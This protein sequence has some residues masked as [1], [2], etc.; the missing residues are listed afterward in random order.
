M[1]ARCDVS[2]VLHQTVIQLVLVQ[3]CKLLHIREGSEQQP[4]LRMAVVTALQP[5]DASHAGQAGEATCTCEVGSP[6]STNLTVGAARRRLVRRCRLNDGKPMSRLWRQRSWLL[7]SAVSGGAELQVKHL[8]CCRAGVRLRQC[9][10]LRMQK[11]SMFR[12]R[13]LRF[14][15]MSGRLVLD[16]LMSASSRL[17]M[18]GSREGSSCNILW[19]LGR[20]S[21]AVASTRVSDKGE[22]TACRGSPRKSGA[23]VQRHAET[24]GR[25]RSFPAAPSPSSVFL[26]QSCS[27]SR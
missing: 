11:Q 17:L 20:S 25:G 16:G 24:S 27:G 1:D 13:M 18:P 8:R 9:A 22:G 6:R 15:D 26:R 21:V 4:E 10:S 2:Q 7:N 5:G 23:G 14:R 3:K 12:V 19:A